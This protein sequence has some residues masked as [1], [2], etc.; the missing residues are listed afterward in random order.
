MGGGG[1]GQLAFDEKT[2]RQL[3]S[4]YLRRDFQR[5]RELV[6]QAIGSQPGE[7]VLD[8]GCGPGFYIAELAALVGPDG[9]A[10]GI[11]PSAD[12]LS[13]AAERCKGHTNIA[14]HEAP[15]TSLPFGDASFDAALSVQVLEYVEDVDGALA[16][17]HRVLR[18]GGRLVLWDVD[19]S[20]VSWYSADGA[21]MARVLRAWEGHLSHPSLPRTLVARLRRAG[22]EG[23][24][25][26]GHTFATTEF[27][28]ESYGVSIIPLITGYV[29]G[30]DGIAKEDAESW[31]HE[32]R[33][34][35]ELGQFFFACTQFS[36]KATRP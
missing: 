36:F 23:V 29:A 18:P 17:M 30:K 9:E 6:H 15:A 5:R 28:P 3:E 7:R 19:W 4:Y 12:M 8:I 13:L 16:E 26:E 1:A 22:F 34:L 31:A 14:F 21:R 25:A 20:T 11:D 33:Q 32:Q 27:T 2:S 35:G 24:A 10:V